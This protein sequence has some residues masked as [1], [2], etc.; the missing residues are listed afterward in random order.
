MNTKLILGVFLSPIVVGILLF[1]YKSEY[2]VLEELFIPIVVSF[3]ALFLLCFILF[4]YHMWKAVYNEYMEVPP[5]SAVL[6]LLIPIVN[7]FWAFGFYRDF[8]QYYNKNIGRYDLKSRLLPIGGSAFRA[9]PVLYVISMLAAWIPRV[10]LL[11]DAIT[12]IIFLVVVWQTC[13]AVNAL[14]DAVERGS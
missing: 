3:A 1:A 11:L 6:P 8:V 14:A 5:S 2:D 7:I 10:S 12:Y 9:L 13:N 4:H